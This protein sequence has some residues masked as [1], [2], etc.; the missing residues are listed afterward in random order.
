MHPISNAELGRG[1]VLV[2]D[3]KDKQYVYKRYEDERALV[4]VAVAGM[5]VDAVGMR[6]AKMGMRQ[7]GMKDRM[8]IIRS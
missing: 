5:V 6:I 1:H 8:M 7:K 4:A 2:G 3:V